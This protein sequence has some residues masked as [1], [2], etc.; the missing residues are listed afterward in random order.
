MIFLYNIYGITLELTTK[1]LLSLIIL[2]LLLFRLYEAIS[3][4]NLLFIFIV[5]VHLV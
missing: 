3:L 5:I 4:K 2:T 1:L